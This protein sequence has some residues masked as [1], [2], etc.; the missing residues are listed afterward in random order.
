M[1]TAPM[2]QELFATGGFLIEE[3]PHNASRD[4]VTFDNTAGTAALQ[5]EAGTVLSALPPTVAAQAGQSNTGNG[6]I[7]SLGISLA[8][9]QTGSYV[10]GVAAGGVLTVVAPDGTA[11]PPGQVGVPYLQA[12]LGYMLQAGSIPFAPGD[13]FTILVVA[14]MP[15]MAIPK[16]GNIGNG[17]VANLSCYV[18]AAGILGNYTVTFTDPANPTTF[19]VAAPDGRQLPAGTV[20]TPNADGI[21]FTI[22]G[23]SVA[24]STGD[25]FV[26]GVTPGPAGRFGIWDG[27]AVA[28]AVIYSTRTV[29]AGQAVQVAAIMRKAEV[30]VAGLRFPRVPSPAAQQTAI[31]QLRA[32]GIVARAAV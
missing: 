16:A 1:T 24:F 20:G 27:S 17:S 15:P 3:E 14:G 13:G 11:L 12:D 21:A 30:S 23:G 31:T 26:V 9:G 19:S 32:L 4:V 29:P 5:V 2:V 8:P 28:A 6:T 7:G 10:I 22:A 18:A 25:T